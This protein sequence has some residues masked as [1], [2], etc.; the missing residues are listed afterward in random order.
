MQQKQKQNKT[1]QKNMERCKVL[2]LV[3]AFPYFHT[4]G[5]TVLLSEPGKSNNKD[6]QLCFWSEKRFLIR[7]VLSLL[8]ESFISQL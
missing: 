3:A 6:V 2:V 7:Y 4:R 5:R 1:K 8:L